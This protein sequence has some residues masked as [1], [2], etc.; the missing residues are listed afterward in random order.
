MLLAI[1]F[2]SDIAED[3]LMRCLERGLLVNKVK[4]N[5]LRFIPP[6]TIKEADIDKALQILENTL[7]SR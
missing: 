4:P 6:L 2:S 3:L 7:N 1:S 5:T